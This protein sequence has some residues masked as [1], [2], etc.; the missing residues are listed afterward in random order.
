MTVT[1]LLF[2]FSQRHL[3]CR[4]HAEMVAHVS[5]SMTGRIIDAYVHWRILLGK[6]AKIVS[7]IQ[8]RNWPPYAGALWACHKSSRIVTHSLIS[9]VKKRLRGMKVLRFSA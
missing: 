8:A 2:L 5:R 9:M 6:I 4:I 1:V 3:A 7:S